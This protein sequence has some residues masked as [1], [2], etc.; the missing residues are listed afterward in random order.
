MSGDITA[1]F[2]LEFV[3]GITL[4]ISI[5]SSSLI[6]IGRRPQRSTTQIWL[7]G[8]E[9]K[10][11][12][13]AFASSQHQLQSDPLTANYVSNTGSTNDHDKM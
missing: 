6:E 13:I 2:R 5:D 1:V 9:I 4:R 8:R 12:L 10:I 11:M 3:A 7:T